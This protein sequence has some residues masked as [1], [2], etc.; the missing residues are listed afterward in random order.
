MEQAEYGQHPRCSYRALPALALASQCADANEL[1]EEAISNCEMPV[2]HPA[3]HLL[4]TSYPITSIPIPEKDPTFWMDERVVRF[5]HV[6]G[7]RTRKQE[8]VN[9]LLVGRAGT[10]KSSLPREFAAMNQRP[11]FTMHCQLVTEPGD[12]WGNREMSPQR[13]TYFR[14]AALVDAL[15]TPGCVILLDEANRTHPENLNA[16]FGLMDHRRRV[17]IPNLNRE[18]EVAPG[19]VFFVTLNEGLD[20]MGTNPVDRA[21]R[22]RLSNTLRLEYLPK[23]VEAELL[24][25]RTGVSRDIAHKLAEFAHTVRN[26][27]K[28]GIVVSTR[29][30]LECSALVREGLPMADAVMFAIV[31]GA[32]EDMDRKALLQSLQ[33]AG[34]AGEI[35]IEQQWDDGE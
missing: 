3:V 28:L 10:G 17:W 23:R 32:M 35:H 12:W 26:N 19:V 9:V 5:L 34:A 20:Y 7:A 8:I 18:V 22:D 4:Q 33:M 27:P 24:A 13:G 31:N 6:L 1:T 15:E 11:F 30:L 21:L 25:Q 29:Q 2:E 14:K 16:L